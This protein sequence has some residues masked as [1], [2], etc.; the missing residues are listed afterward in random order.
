[1]FEVWHILGLEWNV[2]VERAPLSSAVPCSTG[3]VQGF[4]VRLA[5]VGK[6]WQDRRSCLKMC[7]GYGGT[8]RF[9]PVGTESQAEIYPARWASGFGLGAL[10]HDSYGFF[11]RSSG[12]KNPQA[13][14]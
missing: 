2:A 1:M 5:R 12:I 9:S 14:L 11:K 4:G 3:R 8:R 7:A 10:L 13:L 6:Q